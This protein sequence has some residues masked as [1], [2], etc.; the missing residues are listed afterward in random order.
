[1]KSNQI[2]ALERIYRR[3]IPATD[4]LTQDLARFLCLLSQEIGRQVGLFVDR[5][6]QV[7][8]VFV[9]DSDRIVLPDFGR[10]RA[11]RGRFRGLRLIHTHLHQG[12]VDEDDLTDLTLLRL[13][14]VV[15]ITLE[16]EDMP[17]Q[18]SLAHLLPEGSD[19]RYYKLGPVPLEKLDLNF[20]EMIDSLEAEFAKTRDEQLVAQK[21]PGAIL[22]HADN[23]PQKEAESRIQEMEDLAQTAGLAIVGV[24]RQRRKKPDPK[25]VVGKGKLEEILF[26]AMQKGVETIL[27][28]SDLRA[29]QAR[30]VTEMTD[31]KVIDRTML[32]LDIFAQRAKTRAGK[33]Q[34]ELAQLRYALPRLVAKNT[35]MSRLTGGIGGRG[36]GE[37][38]LEVNRRR[39]R[40]RIRDLQEDIKK[41]SRRRALRRKRRN[42][43][44]LPV[45][46]LV[47][48]TNAGKSTLLNTLTQSDVLTEDKLFATLDPT[49]RRLRFPRDREIIITD[50]VGFLHELPEDLV[51]AFKATL[52][53]LYEAHL[54]VHVVDGADPRFEEKQE[55]VEKILV[56]ME[57]AETPRITVY[58]KFDK[59]N[60]SVRKEHFR[61]NADVLIS[62]LNAETTRP[63][64]ARI[65]KEIWSEIVGSEITE[66]R[67]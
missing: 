64:L 44:N 16:A 17:V 12:G 65:E 60:E 50:T 59:I 8:N 23:L 18:V 6:G 1:M 22:V 28:G 66:K 34:V 25:Y 38:K 41:I 45:V 5:K 35:M 67:L 3:K 43:K 47:G 19:S 24:V 10:M 2:K 48:Y 26:K 7:E 57:L 54:I 30:A 13:D 52:E 29:S 4:V 15:A 9:G 53:E 49:S 51:R 37:T 55:S 39:A 11:G 63:L 56:D 61:R 14:M 31:L 46:A 42:A 62:A 58:N 33:V 40:K 27:F 32:I 36:P 20:Q 21:L